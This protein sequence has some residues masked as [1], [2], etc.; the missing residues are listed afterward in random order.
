VATPDNKLVDNYPAQSAQFEICNGKVIFKTNWSQFS[1]Y[2][3]TE[4][5]ENMTKED[6][7]ANY[8]ADLESTTSIGSTSDGG[9]VYKLNIFK[10]FKKNGNESPS[11]D[12][13]Y[14]KYYPNWEGT[15]NHT[16]EWE[17]AADEFEQLTHDK[18]TYPVE[19]TRY[20]RFKAKADAP[21]AKYPYIY[22]KMTVS[23]T[24]KDIGPITFAQKI[25]N[26]WF[27]LD[28]ADGGW[29]AIIL[30]VKEPTDGGNIKQINREIRSTLVGN[31]EKI[32]DTHKYFFVPKNVQ[33][34]ALNGKTY[35]ITAQS[36]PSDVKWNHLYCKYLPGVDMHVY[37]EA[38]L[39]EILTNCAID[40]NQGAFTNDKL[41]AANN[42]TYTQIAT[43]DQAT[44]EIVLIKN[45]PCK[46]VLNAIGYVENHA[47]V[48]TEMRTWV[49]VV[50]K[51]NC[52]VAKKTIHEK[53]DLKS[54]L[55]S[56]QRPINMKN[57]GNQVMIDAKTQGNII[58]VLDF[59]KL[60]DWR[61]EPKG[62]MWGDQQWFWAYYNVNY[63]KVNTSPSV[64]TTNMDKGGDTFVPLNSITS[65]AEL[66]SYP[67]MV[68]G[69][70]VYNFDLSSYDYEAANG[71]LLKYMGISP[72]DNSK[73][74]KFGAIAYYNNGD[75]VEKFSIRVP[76]TIGYE[77]GE[78]TQTVQI[79][80]ERTLGN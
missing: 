62:Y 72:A 54:F 11:N 32:T 21:A 50:A 53:T 59:L 30:D 43:L 34:K 16:F 58:Y 51:N 22:V 24:R 63:I 70:E 73:K 60:F 78:F 76:I 57:L 15:T 64:V 56:W 3:L 9:D 23:L 18:A 75:N 69:I 77:W 20:I 39:D 5:L 4:K 1:Y 80:I 65:K 49:N 79:D 55:V 10:A 74:E 13:G 28:G 17:L 2:V 42:G 52:D 12:L 67:S 36:G 31:M 29:D 44:G 7:D 38:K 8:E 68:R 37:D 45:D 25:D 66:Y 40:Y 61:G 33:I 71:N 46:D 14:A 19:I 48:S 41:Y 6:F 27:G 47:N 26:Y 35:T